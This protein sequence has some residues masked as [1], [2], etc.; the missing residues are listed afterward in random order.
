LG[1]VEVDL[2]IACVEGW[3][4][5]AH[6]GGVRLSDVL[7]AAGIP[8]D[9]TVQ[10]IS[11]EQEGAYRSSQVPPQFAR[12]PLTLLATHLNGEPLVLEHG[13]PLRLIAPN[14]PGVLQTKWVAGVEAQ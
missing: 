12:D 1:V 5:Q 10:V 6:W 7:D 2:P 3:S 9:A 11:R 14:R 8:A 13:A 4:T